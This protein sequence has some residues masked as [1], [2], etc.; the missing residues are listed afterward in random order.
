MYGIAELVPETRP[1]L[2]PQPLEA[3]A[4]QE[5]HEGGRNHEPLCDFEG[6][7]SGTGIE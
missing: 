4:R 7:T 2:Q 3:I 5:K 1:L 6:L